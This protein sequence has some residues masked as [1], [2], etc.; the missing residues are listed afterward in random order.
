MKMV[1]LFNGTQNSIVLNTHYIE[2]A[3]N[4]FNRKFM[5]KYPKLPF[6]LQNPAITEDRCGSSCNLKIVPTLNLTVALKYPYAT[7]KDIPYDK[8]NE[9]A[10]CECEHVIQQ[11]YVP[12]YWTEFVLIN[13]DLN[14]VAAHPIHQHGGWFWVVGMGKFNKTI[15]KA[16]IMTE[17]CADCPDLKERNQGL[18]RN[19][20]YPVAKDTIQV[21][22]GGYVILRTPLDNKGV[23]LIHCHIND[24]LL[25]GMAM[26][27]QVGGFGRDKRETQAWCM[28]KNEDGSG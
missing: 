23:W 5:K 15:T 21:P 4:M 13:N 12:G 6:L 14:N 9:N 24:H 25:H 16:D 26:V 18:H 19:F 3:G 20:D 27:F 1:N 28:G 11:P 17:D 7:C 2:L 10:D 8:C 22:P